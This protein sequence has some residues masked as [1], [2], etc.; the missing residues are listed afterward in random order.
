[1]GQRLQESEAGRMEDLL[2][3]ILIKS[4]QRFWLRLWPRS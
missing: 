3:D 4:P 2:R 1:L